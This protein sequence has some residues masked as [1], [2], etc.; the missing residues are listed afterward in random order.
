MKRDRGEPVGSSPIDE[1]LAVGFKHGAHTHLRQQRAVGRCDLR[2]G[3]AGRQFHRARFGPVGHGCGFVVLE[4]SVR[5]L[6]RLQFGGEGMGG[7][8]RQSQSVVQ[9]GAS[10]V[11]IGGAANPLFFDFRA[12]HADGQYIGIGGHAGSAHRFGAGQIRIGGAYGL[13]GLGQG[14]FG[15]QHSVVCAGYRGERLHARLPPFFA[16]QCMRELR[17]AHRLP[18]TAAVIDELI[19][20]ELGLE[21]I[22]GVGTVERS[23]LEIVR[24]KLMLG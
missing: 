23:Q 14:R 5:R 16:G 17:R 24:G 3:Q 9:R 7:V 22:Q 18:C 19:H 13:L 21:I 20:G 10:D 4:G 15:E 11:Q 8:E 6:E 1:A 2:L 12:M